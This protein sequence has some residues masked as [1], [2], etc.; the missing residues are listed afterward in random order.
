MATVEEVARH[1]AGISANDDEVLLVGGW[2][3]QRWKELAN[4][5]T[6]RTLRR[7]GTLTLNP[8]EQEGTVTATIGDPLI[9][10]TGTN[11][12]SVLEGQYIRLVAVWYEIASVVNA[13]TIIMANPF[14]EN[15]SA[16]MGYKIVQQRYRLLPKIRKLAAF[17]YQRTRQII[18]PSSME[19]LDQAFPGRITTAST[20]QWIAEDSPDVDGVKRVEVYPYPSRLDILDYLYWEEAEDLGYREQLPTFIDIEALR[21]GVMIDVMRNEMFKLMREGKQQASE[22]MRNEYRAQETRWFNTHKNRLLSQDDAVDDLEFT[23]L[24]IRAHPTHARNHTIDNAF[25][26]VWSR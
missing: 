20:P 23:L 5:T 19:G 6:L 8:P 25:D 1:V 15:S 10:G 4:T 12:T 22:L 24:N 17:R 7:R 13:T 21:E 9:T 18:I 2:V 16:G 26:Q 11:W 3:N 14:T